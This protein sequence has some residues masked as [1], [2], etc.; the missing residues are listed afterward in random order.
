MYVTESQPPFTSGQLMLPYYTETPPKHNLIYTVDLLS[1][2]YI[3]K[4]V[5]MLM[6]TNSD[7]ETLNILKL[8]WHA[9]GIGL[10]HITVA[11]I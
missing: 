4:I 6:V 2:R 7:A 3:K 1:Y 10:L 8:P 11:E 5:C 9:Q